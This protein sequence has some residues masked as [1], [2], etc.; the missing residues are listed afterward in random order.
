MFYEQNHLV[1]VFHHYGAKKFRQCELSF[2]RIDTLKRHIDSGHADKIKCD[3]CKKKWS[4]QGKVC[5]KHYKNKVEQ[6]DIK[7]LWSW[8][9]LNISNLSGR[10]IAK[11]LITFKLLLWSAWF[12]IQKIFVT[13]LNDLLTFKFL[14]HRLKVLGVFRSRWSLNH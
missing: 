5:S 14:T 10:V 13:N 11:S 4:T 12:L 9:L 8:W 2:G 1:F 6:G 3:F 7:K